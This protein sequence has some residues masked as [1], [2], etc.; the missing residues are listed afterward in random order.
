MSLVNGGHIARAAAGSAAR[1]DHGGGN[2]HRRRSRD[3]A[4]RQPNRG[5]RDPLRALL[6]ADPLPRPGLGTRGVRSADLPRGGAGAQP[7]RQGGWAAGGG[8]LGRGVA[9]PLGRDQSEDSPPPPPLRDPRRLPDLALAHRPVGDRS[10]RTVATS[11]TGFP[12]PSSSRSSRPGFQTRRSCSGSAAPSS[13]GRSSPSASAPDRER[14]APRAPRHP[15]HAS[16]EAWATR[17]S[18]PRGWCRRWSSPAA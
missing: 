5:H 14:S 18:W 1:P 8:I 3:R 6:W 9:D 15:K 17:T 10:G 13:S 2:G 12:S 11:G 16:K 4:R 7:R